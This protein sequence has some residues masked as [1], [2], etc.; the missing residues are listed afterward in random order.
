MIFSETSMLLSEVNRTRSCLGRGQLRAFLKEEEDTSNYL[1][2][3][4]WLTSTWLECIVVDRLSAAGGGNRSCFGCLRLL[5]PAG[6]TLE[7]G[8]DIQGTGGSPFAGEHTARSPDHTRH[9]PGDH[10][11]SSLLLQM[12]SAPACEGMFAQAEA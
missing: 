12:Y 4:I 6:A 3:T 7:G 9:S 2:F 8:V 1:F 5:A 11:G 10:R